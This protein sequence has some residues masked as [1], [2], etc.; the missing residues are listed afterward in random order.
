[1]AWLATVTRMS[2]FNQAIIDEFRGNGGRVGGPF[3]GVPLL[4]LL[5]TG[6]KSGKERVSPLAYQAVG[7]DYAV[8]A[9]KAGHSTHPD[10]YYNLLA[11]P[12]AEIEVGTALIL[13]TAR[14]AEGEERELIWAK[15][16]SDFPAFAEYEAKT[17]RTIPVVILTKR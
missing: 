9:S 6:A 11:H 4:L 3:E 5:T 14:V 2:D 13:V 15:Q 12:N 16:K 10:W 17:D 7:E 8:F 1:M